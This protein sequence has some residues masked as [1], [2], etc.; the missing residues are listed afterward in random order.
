MA[1][2]MSA[3]MIFSPE[4]HLRSAFPGTV[5][6]MVAT[7]ILLRIQ[8]EYRIALLLPN[9]KSFLTGVGVVCFL[10][11]ASV[12]LHHLYQRRIYNEKILG[13]IMAM[14]ANGNAKRMVLDVES[15][16]ETSK[17]Q[18]YLSGY[19][20]FDMNLTED[21][22]SWTNV[23]FARYYRINSVRVSHSSGQ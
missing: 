20:T 2:G 6:L 4:F 13:Q 14:Q 21:A 1:L 5:Q 3:I 10:V 15:Y 23:A 19:H 16:P 17:L 11:S 9:V 12:T 8:E 22:N 18:D 7:G